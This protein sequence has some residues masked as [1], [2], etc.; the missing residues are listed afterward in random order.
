MAWSRLKQLSARL[1]ENVSRK[2][3]V[4]MPM[5]C[6]EASV[7]IT[8]RSCFRV[9]CWQWC[10]SPLR[11]MLYWWISYDSKKKVVGHNRDLLTTSTS[12][13]IMYIVICPFPKFPGLNK[14]TYYLQIHHNSP[15]E[16]L[17]SKI[18]EIVE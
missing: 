14:K 8:Q 18:N 12:R 7:V 9:Y 15:K 6:C 16:I 2:W 13:K 3:K 10:Q 11:V 17:K 4:A 1:S 5:K